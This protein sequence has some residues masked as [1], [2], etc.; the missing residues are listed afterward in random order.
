MLHADDRPV[1]LEAPSRL[2]ADT[3]AG[4]RRAALAHLDD[5]RS[6]QRGCIVIDLSQTSEIDASG[7]GV[8]VLLQK[9]AREAMVGTRLLHA[10][11]AVRRILALA[12]LDHLFEFED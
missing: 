2:I 3:R 4:F 1:T 7:L 12:R 10:P 5:A 6:A 11:E 8:L 9:R